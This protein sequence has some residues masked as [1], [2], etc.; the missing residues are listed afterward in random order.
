MDF[1]PLSTVFALVGIGFGLFM[2]FNAALI[3]KIHIK[4]TARANWRSEP[5]SM[6]KELKNIRK[7][8]VILIIV[9]VLAVFYVNFFIK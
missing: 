7:R 5:I 6:E 4:S 3:I 8:G 1:L 2:I 9:C